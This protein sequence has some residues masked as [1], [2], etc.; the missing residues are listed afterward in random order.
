MR[1][2]RVIDVPPIC[3]AGTCAGLP[4]RANCGFLGELPN[5]GG[6]GMEAERAVA[7]SLSTLVE[8]FAVS[9]KHVLLLLRE[10]EQHGLLRRVRVRGE[11]VMPQQRLV[12]AAVQKR[13][14]QRLLA[15]LAER[16]CREGRG[17]PRIGPAAA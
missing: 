10:A 11:Q 9:R 17:W 2:T 5:S 3:Y 14:R 4:A 13:D 16:T 7:V 15:A 12:H 1:A 6:C 8:R